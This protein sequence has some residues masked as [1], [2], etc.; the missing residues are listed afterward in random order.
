L[1]IAAFRPAAKRDLINH[2]RV[3]FRAL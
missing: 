3:S 2:H 1:I